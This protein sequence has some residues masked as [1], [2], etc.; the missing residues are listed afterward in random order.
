MGLDMYLSARKYLWSHSD[1]DK[2]LARKI[3]ELI[4]LEPK[5][6]NRFRGASLLVKSVEVEAMYWR[7]AYDIHQWFVK[8]IQGG[9][10]NCEEY[11]VQ[12]SQIEELICLCQ[13]AIDNQDTSFFG[14]DISTDDQWFWNSL[15]HTVEELTIALDALP[16]RQYTFYYQSSW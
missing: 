4:D 5:E 14:I 10:D 8:N 16:E 3:N 1:K 9:V 2:E 13:K 11:V 12:H 7:K 6:E 15:K